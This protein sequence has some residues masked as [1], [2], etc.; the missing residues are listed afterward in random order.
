MWLCRDS[1]C[2]IVLGDASFV[3]LCCLWYSSC[4]L[5]LLAAT[6]SLSSR[7]FVMVMICRWCCYC[8]CCGC[9]LFLFF[10]PK[11][12]LCIAAKKYHQSIAAVVIACE[13]AKRLANCRLC[14]CCLCSV[15]QSINQPTNV[16]VVVVVVV[17]VSTNRS[18][19]QLINQ[20]I[21]QS[22]YQVHC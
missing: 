10:F 22:I 18:I 9:C 14:C 16:V 5:I 1:G 20:S 2:V 3:V 13:T 11:L 17:V 19:N 12:S 7:C 21:S 15:I 6:C 8:C 4:G